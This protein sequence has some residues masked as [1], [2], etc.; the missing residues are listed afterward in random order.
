MIGRM[1]SGARWRLPLAVGVLAL[2]TSFA[3]V[4]SAATVGGIGDGGPG[5]GVTGILAD[6]SYTVPA[7]GGTVTGFS[8]QSDVANLGDTLDFLV[9]RPVGA[10]QYEVVGGTGLVALA[11]S[12]TETFP[13]DIQ[14]QAGDILGFFQNNIQNCGNSGPGSIVGTPTSDPPDGATVTLPA[15]ASGFDLNE[16][17]TLVNFGLTKTS[18][19]G[20]SSATSTTGAATQSQ[21]LTYTLAYTNNSGG[22]TASPSTTVQDTLP[23]G[24][25]FVTGSSGCTYANTGSTAGTFN[26]Q[27]TGGVVTCAAGTVADGTGGSFNVVVLPRNTGTNTDLALVASGSATVSPTA[28]ESDLVSS[29]TNSSCGTTSG[30][31]FTGS[32]IVHS[33]TSC[34]VSGV[35][36]TGS[37]IV[38]SG[39]GLVLTNSTVHGSLS[40][41]GATVLTVCG[42]HVYGSAVVSHSTGR[43]VIGSAIGDCGSAVNTIGGSVSVSSNTNGLEL[44]GNTIGGAVSATGNNGGATGEVVVGANTISG[45]LS[46][47]TNT[48]PPTD[49]G[50]ANTATL[51]SGQC[52][53]L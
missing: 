27:P 36:V 52:S 3:G 5:C 31:T 12:G 16:S 28:T 25:Q 15:L 43:V 7:G 37:I 11:G 40:A 35:N 42:S 29:A 38:D 34:L 23:T 6:T 9:L 21:P 2:G 39:G 44:F 4:A 1:R 49:A 53:A 18:S 14:A 33:G 45:P 26:G 17:A 10:G 30:G 32:I 51:K 13:A 22:G 20:G 24:S 19:G 8:F 48:P 41:N 47:S 46:C 50:T